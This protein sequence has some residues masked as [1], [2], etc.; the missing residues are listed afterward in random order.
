[1]PVAEDEAMGEMAAGPRVEEVEVAEGEE[2]DD[3]LFHGFNKKKLQYLILLNYIDL[4]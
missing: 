1:M 3:I 2:V 4:C